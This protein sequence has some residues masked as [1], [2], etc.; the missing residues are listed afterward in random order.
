MILE[1]KFIDKIVSKESTL[2][3][4]NNDSIVVDENNFGVISLI[5]HYQ[6]LKGL[7]SVVLYD[8]LIGKGAAMIINTF[9]VESIYANTITKQALEILSKKC[10]VKYDRLVDNILNRDKSDLCPIEKIAKDIDDVNTLLVE[11]KSFYIER[12]FIND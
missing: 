3:V 11:L 1:H 9:N 7:S 8:K 6:N 2:I 5:N 12:G 4:V 10:D